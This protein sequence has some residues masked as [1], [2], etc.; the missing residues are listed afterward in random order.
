MPT[1]DDPCFALPAVI[2]LQTHRRAEI[3][4]DDLISCALYDRSEEFSSSMQKSIGAF[5]NR[6]VNRPLVT[7]D[8][9][10]FDRVSS[11]ASTSTPCHLRSHNA[12]FSLPQGG[13]SPAAMCTDPAYIQEGY[14]LLALPFLCFAISTTFRWECPKADLYRSDG[15]GRADRLARSRGLL[16]RQSHRLRD[17]KP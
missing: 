13:I 1:C 16:L 14:G 6:S 17:S 8:R 15:L 2:L 12:K 10:G 9:L 11:A 3:A 5:W 4:F 7:D